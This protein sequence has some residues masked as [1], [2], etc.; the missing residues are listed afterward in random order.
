[1]LPDP[2]GWW[3]IYCT[4]L[5][6]V[7]YRIQK[8]VVALSNEK[9]QSGADCS[10]ADV[11]IV[12]DHVT[13]DTS[14]D[15]QIIKNRMSGTFEQSISLEMSDLSNSIRVGTKVEC[16]YAGKGRYFPGKI[17]NVNS[18][19]TLDIA[20]D[21]GDKERGVQP[22]MVRLC[23]NASNNEVSNDVDGLADGDPSV[24]TGALFDRIF[25]W[26]DADG[27]GLI[28]C[29]E[30]KRWSSTVGEDEISAEDFG[31]LCG[32]LGC[33]A[34]KGFT[35]SAFQT[36]YDEEYSGKQSVHWKRIS[37]SGD[38]VDAAHVQLDIRNGSK[39]RSSASANV[40]INRSSFSS[41]S[42]A[43]ASP[44]SQVTRS[45]TA[46]NS[47]ASCEKF[48]NSMIPS[49]N[50][51]SD[52]LVPAIV[53]LNRLVLAADNNG[54]GFLDFFDVLR[55]SSKADVPPLDQASY[56]LLCEV[57]HC[58]PRQGISTA[59]IHSLMRLLNTTT[60]NKTTNEV[61][62]TPS[63]QAIGKRSKLL[64]ELVDAAR[65]V[66]IID[67]DDECSVRDST[68][69]VTD[70]SS[71]SDTEEANIDPRI[72][73]M[74]D[75][76]DANG[77][78]RLSRREFNWLSAQLGHAPLSSNSF[79]KICNS[80]QCDPRHGL[81][82][83]ALSTA[84]F[85]KGQ[86]L[87][88]S[89]KNLFWNHTSQKD[90][91]KQTKSK[92]VLSASAEVFRNKKRKKS[93]PRNNRT[94]HP[95]VEQPS[96][97]EK[98]ATMSHFS[99]RKPS[100]RYIR[101]A[102]SKQSRRTGSRQS[103][104]T[105]LRQS[106]RTGLRQ[107][108]RS[109][110]AF[111]DQSVNLVPG[112]EVEAAIVPGG[113]Y[114]DAVV[115]SLRKD[116]KVNIKFKNGTRADGLDRT[117]IRVPQRSINAAKMLQFSMTAR[118]SPLSSTRRS[119]ASRSAFDKSSRTVNIQQV[120]EHASEG[121]PAREHKKVIP[122][123]TESEARFNGTWFRCKVTSFDPISETYSIRYDSGM[124]ESGRAI[125]DLR[126]AEPRPKSAT[127]PK[128]KLVT[129]RPQFHAPR[130]PTSRARGHPKGHTTRIDMQQASK[131]GVLANSVQQE[132]HHM[133]ES[134]RTPPI[135]SMR[136]FKDGEQVECLHRVLGGRQSW[137]PAEV[138]HYNSITGIALYGVRFL[139]GDRE[140]NVT[141]DRLRS[142]HIPS[143]QTDSADL[144]V[145][146]IGD[147]ISCHDTDS[148][149]ILPGRVVYINPN[150]T[151]D[152]LFH[153]GRRESAVRRA[154]ITK[155]GDSNKVIATAAAEVAA[156]KTPTPQ[157]VFDLADADGDGFIN[158]DEFSA[159]LSIVGE[160]PLTENQFQDL[161]RRLQ[162]DPS[163]GIDSTGWKI[164]YQ[165]AAMQTNILKHFET[166]VQQAE[167]RKKATFIN[168]ARSTAE[169]SKTELASNEN[170]T[171]KFE[172]NVRLNAGIKVS[173]D[174]HGKG[175]YFPGSISRVN[176]DGTYDIL[177]DD[178]D[179]ERGVPYGHIRHIRRP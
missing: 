112:L 84:F 162:C 122:V 64:R 136:K 144:G 173:V 152:I 165:D 75:Y 149:Q 46:S 79:S 131:G 21:D 47:V 109:K 159:W 18:N 87:D 11:S 164:L 3:T 42:D 100:S 172:P 22:D 32:V 107:S 69:P 175:K 151:Y 90:F 31:E 23:G 13:M 15:A 81:S 59:A 119:S 140:D 145:L 128:N 127:S 70:V 120:V 103:R 67:S 110:R 161:V 153:N 19:G 106:R 5:S 139:G 66:E 115:S 150:H 169:T 168:K 4:C 94:R 124:R 41:T 40:E 25:A 33:D 91:R 117:L 51:I 142:L 129:A 157:H 78:G 158:V 50:T 156:G 10:A 146:K 29:L 73:L 48:E 8:Q 1:M 63:Q 170:A 133:Q 99:D 60:P 138:T 108:R 30:L 89:F 62:S 95:A 101:P 43:I 35:R 80:L 24:R 39:G 176:S 54:N 130:Q 44:F 113:K 36:V 92:G 160:E 77:N 179:K 74:F 174:Y 88:T 86:A 104:R 38:K 83:I 155:T 82:V 125:Q 57:L 111:A 148:G 171:T 61:N 52:E 116:G 45:T 177:Y 17:S 65:Q 71:R 9:R 49:E 166:L 132:F 114:I 14:N 135:Q 72:Q 28:N 58:D 123:G 7:L 26:A 68:E 20:Y 143:P 98:H 126:V 147:R 102:R 93:R 137:L 34:S 134:Q 27:D 97:Y 2:R 118:R 56:D 6:H 163:L 178:G 16:N 37:E 167:H 12:S 85:A 76:A 105:G 154:I 96:Q 55:L 141:E 53:A 121:R